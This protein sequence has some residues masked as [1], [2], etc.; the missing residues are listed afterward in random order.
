[1]NVLVVLASQLVGARDERSPGCC[2]LWREACDNFATTNLVDNAELVF[3]LVNLLLRP[4]DLCVCDS[5]TALHRTY[6]Q[7][8]L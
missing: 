6:Q 7:Q 3:D 8:Y 1:M 5:V 2:V 4:V